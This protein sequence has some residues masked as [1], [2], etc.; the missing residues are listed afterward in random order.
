[1][2]SNSWHK[3]HKILFERC[4]G[5]GSNEHFKTQSPPAKQSSFKLAAVCDKWWIKQKWNVLMDCL[6]TVVDSPN[7][8]HAHRKN[9]AGICMLGY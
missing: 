5:F 2:N 3:I 8:T 6:P 1:M 4:S 7:V 9:R